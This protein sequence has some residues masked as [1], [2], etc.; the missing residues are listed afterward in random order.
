LPEHVTFCPY[1][2]ALTS[3]GSVGV[4]ETEFDRITRDS[5][6]QEHWI[7]RVVAY[8]IDWIVVTIA[9]GI[10]FLIV[11]GIAGITSVILTGPTLTNF[12]VPFSAVGVGVFGLQALFFLLYFTFSEGIYHK[13]VGKSLLRLQVSTTDGS[14]LDVTKA[15][16]RNIS[17]I[18]WLL[19]LLDLIGG[20][21]TK[22]T[23][24]QRY[25][26]RIAGTLVI[27]T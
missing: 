12:F 20:F 2:G 21:F 24:G 9:T 22:V 3:T 4:G 18:Y 1:C 15:F 5:R 25:L 17:K 6:T 26:D 14:P 19:L 10:I 7:R 11:S 13:T 16:I 23:P 27:S 8:I